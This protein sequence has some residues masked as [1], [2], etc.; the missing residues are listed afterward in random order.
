MDGLIQDLLA[1]GRLSRAELKPEVVNLASVVAEAL[2]QMQGEIE[3]SRAEVTV[4]DALPAVTGHR[5]TLLQAVSNLLSNAVKFAKA[6]TPARIRV[7]SELREGRV[8]LWVED[9]GI[10]I[11]PEYHERIFRVFERLH[12]VESYPGTGIG[13]AI[14]HKGMER[15]GGQAGVESKPG[16]GSRFWIELPAG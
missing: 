8:R 15:L 7:R 12:G 14:V 2:E 3:R 6:D 10:G 13:L 16:E 5:A 11:D 1:Y 4:D 9:N